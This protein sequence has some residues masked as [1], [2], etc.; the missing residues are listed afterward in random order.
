MAGIGV[1]VKFASELADVRLLQ[2]ERLL[3]WMTENVGVEMAEAVNIALGAV[4][5]ARNAL[6]GTPQVSTS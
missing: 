3:E 1:E 5:D 6:A 2:T 4:L